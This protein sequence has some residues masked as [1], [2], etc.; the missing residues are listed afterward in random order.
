MKRIVELY[1]QGHIKPIHPIAQFEGSK[2]EDAMRFMQK[3]NHIGKIVV[4]LPENPEELP[5]QSK[6]PVFE[7]C[8]NA[9][10]LLV[11]GLGGLGQAIAVWM[12]E[13]GAKEGELLLRE[14][15]VKPSR[16]TRDLVIFLSR[17]AGA[18]EK[19]ANVVQELKALGCSAIMVSGSVISEKDVERAIKMATK[20]VRGVIQAS[21]VLKVGMANYR[22]V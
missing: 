5:T 19:Y 14:L 20:P 12:A 1:E 10:Y 15:S 11:G 13:S 16:L 3:G 18:P 6:K 21:M 17:S 9:S 8:E 2:V 7:L 4:T 22:N